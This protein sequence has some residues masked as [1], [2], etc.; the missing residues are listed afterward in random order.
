MKTLKNLL[1]VSTLLFI[2][3]TTF[4][5][6]WRVNNTIG[7]SANFT[8]AQAAHNDVNVLN[9]DTIM[10]EGSIADYGTLRLTKRLILIGTGYFLGNN[11]ET[12]ASF[13]DSKLSTM[14][15]ANGSQNSSI[16]GFNMIGSTINI[17]T[18]NITISRNYN[19][20]TL[21]VGFDP[22]CC[23]ININNILITQNFLIVNL[24]TV[25]NPI[26]TNLLVT[27]NLIRNYGTESSTSGLV[28]N[29]VITS[30]GNSLRATNTLFANNILTSGT[31]NP[32]SSNNTYSN[33]ISSNTS[34]TPSGS[35]IGS[36]NQTNINMTDVFTIPLSEI[37]ENSFQLKNPGPGKNTAQGGGDCGIF[38][39]SS[40][41]V[42]SGMPAIPSVY[43]FNIPATGSNTNPL[44]IS[45]KAKS[46][47]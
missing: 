42:L 12:Q 43:F 26:V 16:Q 1:I 2:T 36:N 40:P 8:T 7:I 45:S 31:I 19:I 14:D 25:S 37:N 28:Q 32:V 30:S 21:R 46:R 9:G 35:N 41:Y 18:S 6:I 39:G 27:N 17:G 33:N 24:T 5:K 13:L 23:Q 20:G 15:F 11:P 4:A 38:G 29:N 10:F 34:F 3:N 44:N 47:N 22:T